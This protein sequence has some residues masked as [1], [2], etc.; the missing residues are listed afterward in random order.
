MILQPDEGASLVRED[1]QGFESAELLEVRT[2]LFH[3]EVSAHDLD[4]VKVRAHFCLFV[5]PAACCAA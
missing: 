4:A 1:L 3:I 2:Q 5:K